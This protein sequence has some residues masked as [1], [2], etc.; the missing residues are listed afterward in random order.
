MNIRVDGCLSCAQQ[1][2]PGDDEIYVSVGISKNGAKLSECIV[3]AGDMNNGN[4]RIST[5]RIWSGV[6]QPNEVWTFSISLMEDDGGGHRPGLDIAGQAAVIAGAAIGTLLGGPV[7]AGIGTKIGG[8]A[9]DVLGV[10]GGNT[11]DY[12]G[13]Y[14]LVLEGLSDGHIVSSV[15]AVNRSEFE[16]NGRLK[17]TG[18]GATYY[19]GLDVNGI[20]VGGPRVV[21]L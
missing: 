7:G 17:C 21:V 19:P 6:I 15:H 13:T 18:D 10:I 12:I 8:A 3:W 4:K 14:I 11:D 16:G 9:S 20:R 2:E 5:F 1:N